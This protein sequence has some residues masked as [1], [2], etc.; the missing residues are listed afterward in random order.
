MKRILIVRTSAIGD[1]V[2]ASP[3]AAVALL[4]M[5]LA[6]AALYGAHRVAGLLVVFVLCQGAGNGVMSIS[7]PV[8]VA[9]LLG[10]RRYGVIAGML[11]MPYLGC[12]A[13]GPVVGGL[14]WGVA[15][16]DGVL[17]MTFSAGVLGAV[18]LMTAVRIRAATPLAKENG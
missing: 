17:A 8:I 3:I 6:S 10:R 15:G 14:M 1:I 11:A 13:L 7:R 5:A 18:A 16:Y 4:C 12:I 2:F 9:D